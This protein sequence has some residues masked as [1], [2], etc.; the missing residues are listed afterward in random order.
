MLWNSL[1]VIGFMAAVL[2]AVSVYDEV[3]SAYRRARW[4]RAEATVIRHGTRWASAGP[5]AWT[6]FRSRSAVARYTDRKGQEHTLE[7]S[8]RV[9]GAPVPIL[10]SPR[11]PHRARLDSPPYYGVCACFLVVTAACWLLLT[12]VPHAPAW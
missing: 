11:R 10:V 6:A 2:S 12:L 1:T 5:P 3:T 8:D 4:D 7:V 9:L